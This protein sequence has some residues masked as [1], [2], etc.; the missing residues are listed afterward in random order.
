MDVESG[1]K[2]ELSRARGEGQTREGYRTSIWTVELLLTGSM[3]G[4]GFVE[5]QQG[6]GR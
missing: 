3:D 2:E 1:C 6:V 4:P 5:Q